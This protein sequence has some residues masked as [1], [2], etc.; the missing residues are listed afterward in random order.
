MI[1]QGKIVADEETQQVK[2]TNGS[3]QTI[4]VEFKEKLD[5]EVVKSIPGIS[6]YKK[7]SDVIW[8]I[9][10][11]SDQDLREKI[12]QFAMQNKLNILEM[13]TRKRTLEDTFRELS[14]K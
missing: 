9:E 13:Q 8:Y 2:K 7:Q 1:N 12:F 11:D 3:R 4:M 14:S 6:A 5:E 10:S